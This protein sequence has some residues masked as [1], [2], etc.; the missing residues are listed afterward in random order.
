MAKESKGLGRGAS[1]LQQ[2]SAYVGHRAPGC[3]SGQAGRRTQLPCCSQ[4]LCPVSER[5][6]TFL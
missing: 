2:A 6:V 1:L 5:K 3:M 4:L